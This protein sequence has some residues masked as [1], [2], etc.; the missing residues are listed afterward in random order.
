MDNKATIRINEREAAVKAWLK[1]LEEKGVKFPIL[2]ERIYDALDNINVVEAI[3]TFTL[4]TP[5]IIDLQNRINENCL[6]A[7]IF[8]WFYSGSQVNDVYA[9]GILF[10]TC[11]FNGEPSK[12][13]LLKIPN[14]AGFEMDPE[15]GDVNDDGLFA[16]CLDPVMN[17]WYEKLSKEFDDKFHE[18][19]D[20][21]A[22]LKHGVYINE[23]EKAYTELFH[24][25]LVTLLREAYLKT[26]EKNPMQITTGKPFHLF[27]QTHERWPMHILSLNM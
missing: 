12:T 23:I 2:P 11:V 24:L 18:Y 5:D 1:E 25:K 26:F 9:D 16:F 17:V 19:R 7:L 6:E 3:Q 8:E 21:N 22:K 20:L 27:I 4:D 14:C 10:E 15:L 13:D